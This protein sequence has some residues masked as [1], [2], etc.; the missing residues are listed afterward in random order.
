MTELNNPHFYRFLA[1]SNIVCNIKAENSKEL[2]ETLAERLCKTT[3]GLNKDSIV[4][5]VIARENVV[6]TVIAPGLAVPHA[7]MA[8]VDRLLVALE[9]RLMVSILILPVCLQSR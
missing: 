8:D 1:E 3:A 9:P 2:I 4:D 6:P 5:A 7:R